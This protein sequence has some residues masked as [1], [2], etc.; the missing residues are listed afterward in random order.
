[1]LDLPLRH[2][3]EGLLTA[4]RLLRDCLGVAASGIVFSALLAA[5]SHGSVVRR[6]GVLRWIAEFRDGG[7]MGGVRGVVGF[8]SL[9]LRLWRL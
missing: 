9:W 4:R 2:Y 7:L 8:R 6:R 5:S 3:S 1:M